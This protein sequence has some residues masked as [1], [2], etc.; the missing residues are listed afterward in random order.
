M[1][2]WKLWV[3]LKNYQ[4][5][6]PYQSWATEFVEVVDEEKRFYKFTARNCHVFQTKMTVLFLDPVVMKHWRQDWKY[7]DNEMSTYIG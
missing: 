6:Q 1:I 5:K 7:E 4:P 2:L 3:L